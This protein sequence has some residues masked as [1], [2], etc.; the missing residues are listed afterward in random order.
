MF[1]LG[2]EQILEN[3]LT[4]VHASA[5]A[6]QGDPTL[7]EHWPMLNMDHVATFPMEEFT[8]DEHLGSTNGFVASNS[9]H[10]IIAFRGSDDVFDLAVNLT[11]SQKP[12]E[13]YEGAVHEGF[14]RALEGVWMEIRTLLGSL[15]FAG[16]SIW[17]T[18]HSLGGALATLTAKKLAQFMEPVHCVTFGQPRVGDPE[19]FQ[20]YQV[21]HHR[22]VNEHDMIPKLPPR[23]VFTRYWHVGSEERMDAAGNLESGD[24]DTSLLEDLFFGRL[25]QSFDLSSSMNEGFL[26]QLIQT[27]L[28]D[29]SIRTY[30]QRVSA[31]AGAAE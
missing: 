9:Q 14:G 18:G 30:V 3:A 16:Q 23:G 12:T 24:G 7:Y 13:I 6:Y 8:A 17:I 29:H 25:A 19:F 10:L 26:D 15:D 11:A 1:K 5:A 28:E 20:N 27:G 22:F 31:L 4:L 21:Q 2:G